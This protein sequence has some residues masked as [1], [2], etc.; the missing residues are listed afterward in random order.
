M[1]SGAS[2]GGDFLGVI[3]GQM[4]ALTDDELRKVVTIEAQD[5]RKEAIDIALAELQRRGIEAPSPQEIQKIQQQSAE[6]Q[7]D[8]PLQKVRWLKFYIFVM[9]GELV[10]ALYFLIMEFGAI[11]AGWLAYRLCLLALLGFLLPGMIRRKGWAYY[12]NWL[13]IA[14]TACMMSIRWSTAWWSLP[15]YFAIWAVPNFIYFKKRRRL[16]G[17]QSFPGPLTKERDVHPRS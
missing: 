6:D 8:A 14:W 7:R 15:I 17:P 9:A 16:F 10:V 13:Y 2:S 11:R 4:A 12:L 3:R 5:Y 1:S